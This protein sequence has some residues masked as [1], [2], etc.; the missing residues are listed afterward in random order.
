MGNER[1]STNWLAPEP[2]AGFSWRGFAG[3][4]T[5]AGGAW[6]WSIQGEC[7]V[8]APP[9]TAGVVYY[10][11]VAPLPGASIEVHVG[12][13]SLR[14]LRSERPWQ[15]I[16]GKVELAGLDSQVRFTTDSWNGR[17]EPFAPGDGRA[18]ALLFKTLR[19]EDSP[20]SGLP[21]KSRKICPYPFSKME[22]YA[23]NFAP[24]CTW[25]LKDELAFEGN[26]GDPWNSGAAQALRRSVLNGTYEFCR[27]EI[28]QAPLLE[29]DELERSDEFELPIAPENLAALRLG[30]TEMPAGPSSVVVLADPRCNLACPSCR[31]GMITT[32]TPQES[33]QLR[34]TDRQLEKHREQL[35]V[36]VLASNGEVFY[37]P[38]L[39]LKLKEATRDRYPRL[40]YV[41]IISNGLLFDEKSYEQL[42][43]GSV[44]IR[45]ARISIDA[46]DAATYKAVRG[47]DW[48]RLQRNLKW[49]SGLRAAGKLDN[50]RLN[51]VVRKENFPSLPAFFALAEGL[52]VDEVFVS[53]AL[54]WTGA[55]FAFAAQD[56]FRDDHP[57]HAEFRSL[58][59]GLRENAWT[60]RV[61]GNVDAAATGS[62][63]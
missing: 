25:W 51:F 3:I 34:E 63:V 21:V 43:P 27:L 40:E 15:E 1:N 61:L 17:P 24:C 53:R 58:W 20:A 10:T 52:R 30:L 46:G 50:F 39:R 7:V 38:F 28:C 55:G 23:P 35:R 57:S 62:R 54:P 5:G 59:R 8:V 36:L 11:F 22:V 6:A 16:S 49:L 32:L 33:E 37:S 29:R 45:K 60:F 19:F 2:R 9:G 14:S 47:G 18:L 31:K 4:E 42:R 41:E 26:D 13:R 44:S 12:G 56:V 48:D